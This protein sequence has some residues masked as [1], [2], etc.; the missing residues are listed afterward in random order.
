MKRRIEYVVSL[1]YNDFVFEN[2]QDALAFATVAAQNAD[3][4]STRVEINVNYWNVPETPEKE[5]HPD[6]PKNDTFF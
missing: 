4:C 5:W 6:D 3:N 2:G 1:Q